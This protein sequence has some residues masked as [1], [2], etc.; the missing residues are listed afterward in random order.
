M[1]AIEIDAGHV[2]AARLTWRGGEATVAA[3]A[4]EPLPAG[5]V[6]PSLARAQHRRRASG[7]SGHRAGG[8]RVS[9][10]ASAARRWSFPIPWPRCRWSDS[11]RCRPA[12]PIWPSWCD[13]R[14]GRRAPFP[15]EQAVVSFTP[16]GKPAEGGQEFIVTLARATISSRSTKQACARAG[17]HAGLVDIATFSIINGVL[18]TGA[19]PVRATGCWSMPRRPTRRWWCCVAAT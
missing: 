15:I 4:V 10:R 18:A 13:G 3:H 6:V 7:R 11:T 1:S 16:G 17:L 5:A 19:A 12:R 8:R 9:A 2:A 14:C